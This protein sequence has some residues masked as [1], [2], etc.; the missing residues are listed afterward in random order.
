MVPHDRQPRSWRATVRMGQICPSDEGCAILIMAGSCRFRSPEPPPHRSVDPPSDAIAGGLRSIRTRVALLVSGVTLVAILLFASAAWH[1]VGQA[2]FALA[3]ERMTAAAG[4]LATSISNTGA[5]LQGQ[6]EALSSWPETGAFLAIGDEASEASLRDRLRDAGVTGEPTFEIRDA[7]GRRVLVEGP[8]SPPEHADRGATPPGASSWVGPLVAPEI[9]GGEEGRVLFSA[10]ARIPVGTDPE[11]EGG[12]LT[13]WRVMDTPAGTRELIEN[14]IDPEARIYLADLETRVWSDFSREVPGPEIPPRDAATE[15]PLLKAT[16]GDTGS[17]LLAALPAPPTPW[18][19]FVALP[20]PAVRAGT[21]PVL[22]WFVLSGSILVMFSGVVGWFLAGHLTKGMNR[23]A[24]AAGRLSRGEA[25]VSVPVEGADEI[26]ALA[27]AFNTMTERV[28]LAR[29]E[30]EDA[31][32]DAVDREAEAREVRERLEHLVTSSR[33][34]L[35]SHELHPASGEGAPVDGPLPPVTWI[36]ENLRWL[37]ALEPDAARAPGWWEERVHPE[38]LPQ[39]RSSVLALRDQESV[40][41]EYRFRHGDGDF[42][43][44]RDERRVRSDGA[45]MGPGEPSRPGGDVVGV[46][47][48]IT[49]SRELEDARAA[50]EV[51]NQAKSEFLSRMSHELRTPL[52]AVLGFGQLLHTEL[53]GDERQPHADQV[54]RAGEHLLGLIDEVLDHTGVEAGRIRVASVPVALPE[55]VEEAVEL[56]RFLARDRGITLSVAPFDGPRGALGDGTRLRQVLVNL[57]TNGIKYNR[58][59]G[60]VTVHLE[61]RPGDRVRVTVA[62][63]GPGIPDTKLERLFVPFDRLGMEEREPEG[64]GLG[65]PLSRSLVE[66]MGGALTVESREGEGSRFHVDLPAAAT[67]APDRVP[68]LPDRPGP[69]AGRGTVLLVED[70]PANVALFQRIFRKRPG[71]RLLTAERG[72]DGIRLARE[73][74]PDLVLLDLNLPDMGGDQVLST[75]REDPATAAAHVVMISGDASP[76]QAERLLALGAQEYLFKPFRIEELLRIVDR[77]LGR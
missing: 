47:T 41:L 33:A 61:E 34:I 57:L 56:V 53:V 71:V 22:I 63:T 64:T 20:E 14:L 19:V 73:H 39:A 66:A 46:L 54:L 36:T 72:A 3:A 1:E 37:L 7:S 51:A 31:A 59:G 49:R 23:L 65:L 32:R 75:L 16:L 70:H 24:L 68:D 4:P 26:R 35:L 77:V 27:Q 55:V 13:I 58:S 17:L 38:D 28:A 62:D 12:T 74:R 25:R 21:Q 76:A 18:T 52:T 50:A 9:P 42:R 11:A 29:E 6:V 8:R 15:G 48:D 45:P 69:E 10:T 5:Q 2:T 40:V 67:P 43:W 44:L 60:A 30:L